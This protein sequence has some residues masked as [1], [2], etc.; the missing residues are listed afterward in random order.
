[1]I[2]SVG[3]LAGMGLVG[4]TVTGASIIQ[5]KTKKGE[6]NLNKFQTAVSLGALTA[7]P[8]LVKEA[9]KANPRTTVKIAQATGTAIEKGTEY[10]VK[11]GKQGLDY[12]AKVLKTE[13]GQKVVSFVNKLKNSKIGNKVVDAVSKVTKKLASN[14]TVQK[15]ITKASEALKN[16]AS[17]STAKKGKIGLI[18]AGVALL[19][20][21]GFKTITNFYKKEGAIEQKYDDLHKK[22]ERMLKIDPITDARTGEP[23]SFYEYCKLAQSMLK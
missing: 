16:F 18:A 1:M 4:A 19:A 15:V 5:P 23:I 22:Y 3:K 20:Y 7:T 10:A 11:Y 6:E 9:V 8:Y 17:S 14:E 21:A 2:S 13:R 12:I